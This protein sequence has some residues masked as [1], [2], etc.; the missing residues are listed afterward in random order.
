MG[1]AGDG[2]QMLIQRQWSVNGG[3]EEYD[4]RHQ[5][6]TQDM[7]V[8]GFRAL[9][10]VGT[11]HTILSIVPASESPPTV[12]GNYDCNPSALSP[13]SQTESFEMLYAGGIDTN[14]FVFP[15]GVAI[16]IP[17]GTYIQ[18]YLHVLN[19][20]DL[21]LTETSGVM[22]KTIPAADVVNEAD[23]MFFGK[24]SFQVDPG[25]FSIYTDCPATEDWHILGLW[26]HMHE[27]G[28]HQNIQVTH[29]GTTMKTPLDVAYSINEQ[30]N[31]AMDFVIPTNDRLQVT[32]TWNNTTGAPIASGESSGSEMCYAGAFMYPKHGDIYGC[33]KL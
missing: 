12:V 11:H 25:M 18:L 27:Y 19:S 1:D 10:P 30:K 17:A 33:V 26:P 15:P 24:R 13:P 6:V 20:G 2:W 29:A 3:L 31:Y 28:V 22:I 23:M 14:D 5:L 8:T 32:C 21:P 4:C 16:K 7:Y 9:A